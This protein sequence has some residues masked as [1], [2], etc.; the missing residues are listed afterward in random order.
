MEKYTNYFNSLKNLKS[1]KNILE[2]LSL[3][4]PDSQISD[5]S[6]KKIIDNFL[7]N[8]VLSEITDKRKRFFISNNFLVENNLT[9]EEIFNKERFGILIGK[10]NFKKTSLHLD[11][12][13]DNS[14]KEVKISELFK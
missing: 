3:L 13:E 7:N 2:E 1:K 11:L 9:I 8:G 10:E 14:I 6:Y 12:I 4:F 5:T